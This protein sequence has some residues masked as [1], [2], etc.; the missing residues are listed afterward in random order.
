MFTY[1]T[2]VAC[3]TAF[4]YEI[5]YRCESVFG[6]NMYIY[7]CFYTVLVQCY[8]EAAFVCENVFAYETAF[9]FETVFA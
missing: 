5:A 4:G 8:L 7:M 3:E 2:V 6:A 1:Q 9:L